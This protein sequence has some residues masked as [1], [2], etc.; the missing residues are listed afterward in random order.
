M[1]ANTLIL[2][3][4][5]DP[6]S[7]VR[8]RPQETKEVLR[9]VQD[10]RHNGLIRDANSHSAWEARTTV[11]FRND[12]PAEFI[13]SLLTA[14]IAIGWLLALLALFVVVPVVGKDKP[15]VQY[16]IAIP[17]PPDYSPLDWLIG[18]WSGATAEKSPPG[19]VH[20]T[21]S[22]DLGKQFLVLREEVSLDSTDTV[23]ATRE[24]WMGVLGPG[25][26]AVGFV[27]QVFSSNGFATRYRVKVDGPQIRLNPEG[28]D[29]PP[30]D[31]LF[32]KTLERTG[33]TEFTE[34]VQAAPPNK[35][36]FDYYTVRLSRVAPA[37]K[38]TPSK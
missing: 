25:P 7:A 11:N 13:R 38:P 34:T 9:C 24:S 21:V 6:L 2:S 30:P 17:A 8:P 22:L 36:F 1:K 15:P 10:E 35:P 12:S 31:W 4:A 19:K 33:A 26:G 27:L 32:R 23:P 28:G 14:K 29:R 37:A 20:L 3:A 5:K 18:E 16:Q